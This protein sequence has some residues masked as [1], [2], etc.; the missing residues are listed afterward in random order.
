MQLPP[1]PELLRYV[2][3]CYERLLPH[4]ASVV[5]HEYYVSYF[6]YVSSFLIFFQFFFIHVFL[7]FADPI[8]QCNL[9]QAKGSR[10]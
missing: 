5:E 2:S 6:H 1:L 7:T 3:V 10:Q 4:S 8:V 9:V